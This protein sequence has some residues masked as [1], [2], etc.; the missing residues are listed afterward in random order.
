MAQR[1][2]PADPRLCSASRLH[3]G[4]LAHPPREVRDRA[5]SH[6]GSRTTEQ[7]SDLASG[8]SPRVRTQAAAIPQASNAPKTSRNV[9]ITI[10]VRPEPTISL[11][12]AGYIPR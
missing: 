4:R 5:P 9:D 12:H 7:R 2:G 1:I 6:G 11:S 8:L 3:L 10:S